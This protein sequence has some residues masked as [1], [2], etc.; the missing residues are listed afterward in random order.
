MRLI[1]VNGIY[2]VECKTGE[3]VSGHCPSVNVLFDSVAKSAGKNALGIILT[4]MGRDGAAGLLHM[5]QAGARTIGQNEASCIVY[6]MPKAAYDDGAVE[7]QAELNQIAAKAY[8]I[9]EKM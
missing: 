3:K 1:K 4:G 2:Q 8:Q 7:I 9:V 5:R 6:G